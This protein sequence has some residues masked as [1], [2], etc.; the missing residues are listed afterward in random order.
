M[1]A[2]GPPR[3]D[4]FPGEDSV[5]FFHVLS[6]VKWRVANDCVAS[7]DYSTDR[8]CVMPPIACPVCGS[9]VRD[10]R[11]PGF[12][13]PAADLG[14]F[15]RELRKK[16]DYG[17]VAAPDEWEELRRRVL[18]YMP[19]EVPITPGTLFG[20]GTIEAKGR[21]ADCYPNLQLGDGRFMIARTALERLRASGVSDLFAVPVKVLSKRKAPD[22]YFELQI[23]HA[24]RLHGSLDRKAI[25]ADLRKIDADWARN[26][27][28]VCDRCGREEGKLPKR[29]ILAGSSIPD[30]VSLFRLIQ[31]PRNV[32]C[33]EPFFEAV[34]KLKLTNILFEPVKTE[35]SEKKAGFAKARPSRPDLWLGS[36]GGAK[37][38]VPQKKPEKPGKLRKPKPL[39]P[40]K[41][42]KLLLAGAALGRRA[43]TLEALACRGIRF[44]LTPVSRLAVG[45]SRFGGLPDLPRGSDWPS[46]QGAQLDFLLQVNLA[47]L[48]RVLPESPLPKAGWLW[49][50]YDTENCPWGGDRDDWNGWQVSYWDGPAIELVRALAPDWL[51]TDARFPV[52]SLSLQRVEWLPDYKAP[53]VRTLKLSE[54]ELTAY[55][56]TLKKLR[57]PE[58]NPLHK[59]L[60]WPDTI[61]NDMAELCS[62]VVGGKDWRILLQLDSEEGA[63]MMWG[64]AGRLYFWIR[65]RDLIARRFDRCWAMLQCF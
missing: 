60:G 27:V 21:F 57:A 38:T 7:A 3:R 4:S 61:Q 63:G 6:D 55:R 26:R 11:N 18:T 45:R 29:I 47:E 34:T 1:S 10:T 43:A 49:F 36:L 24:A 5:K 52:C 25:E 8:R 15:P 39:P 9:A 54:T 51:A 20:P 30:Q 33:T 12:C 65:E 16:L 64:D 41:P 46:R 56:Q 2:F 35:G 37:A 50:F 40:A 32:F 62:R 42:V 19:Y 59:L 44:G 14:R 13:Y 17:T 48:T 23:E 53:C 22:E 31:R 58:G 28:L